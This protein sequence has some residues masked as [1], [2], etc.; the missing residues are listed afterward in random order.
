MA[1]LMHVI[2]RDEAAYVGDAA[3]RKTDAAQ[4]AV[5]TRKLLGAHA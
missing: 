2:W 1:V 4:A 5:K 3:A